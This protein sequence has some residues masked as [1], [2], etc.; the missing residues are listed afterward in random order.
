VSIERNSKKRLRFIT[1]GALL[2]C[3]TA[4]TLAFFQNRDARRSVKTRPQRITST[5][6]SI[7]Q[8]NTVQV[9]GTIEPAQEEDLGF[10]SSGE[11]AAVYVRE[12][13][14]VEAGELIAELD[15]SEQVYDLA[16]LDQDIERARI[17]G[18]PGELKLLLLQRDVKE[19]SLRKRKLYTPISGT[20][21]EVDIT[22]GELTKSENEI[23]AVVR[24]IDL[25]S[26]KAEVEIDELDVPMVEVGQKV[27]F[28]FD[29]LPELE[30]EGRVS[31]LPLE[32]RLTEEGIAVLDAELII[33]HPPVEI[34]SGYSFSAEI[35]I[36]EDEKILLLD[37]YA[38]FER[39][40][41]TVVLVV[42]GDGGTPRQQAVTAEAYSEGKV[43]IVSGLAE[44][45]TVIAVESGIGQPG[46]EGEPDEKNKT[47]LLKMLGMP[48]GPGR[49]GPV[50]RSPG[51][52]K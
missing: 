43:R 45:D 18:S 52:G 5:V 10:L 9:T 14:H 4:F 24:V 7:L 38:V 37:D 47:S 12:G 31:S 49:G 15:D 28:R 29:A 2:V 35:V 34:L 3:A 11:V 51:G 39:D 22:V 40:G 17:S 16:Q 25:S 23:N 46:A 1:T 6:T 8:R 50:G 32:A 26:M 41:K 19:A 20:I 13:D 48:G 21:S 33:D 42:P 44:G 27:K 36:G 30:V